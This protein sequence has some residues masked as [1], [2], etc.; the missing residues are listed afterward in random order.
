M[1][2]NRKLFVAVMGE[3]DSGKSATWNALFNVTI[4]TNFLRRGENVRP[5]KL[6]EFLD[7]DIFLF[8]GSI[9]ENGWTKEEFNK[10]F[11]RLCLDKNVKIVLCSLQTH[12]NKND[13]ITVTAPEV[14]KFV[15]LH[16]FDIFIQWL[17]PGHNS[18]NE[19]RKYEQTIGDDII[20]LM[21]IESVIGISREDATETGNKKQK[22][23]ER[24]LK[25]KEIIYGWILSRESDF[26]I[27]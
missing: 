20:H 18:R 19:E 25:L 7:T 1:Q 4:D 23:K 26:L 24:A 14:L 27:R 11:K 10:E 8:P 13:T 16:D 12:T 3:Q 2:K 5:L 6:T 22:P 15:N 9:Q 21:S 17:Y